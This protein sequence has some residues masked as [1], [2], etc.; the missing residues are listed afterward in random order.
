MS[1]IVHVQLRLGGS[2]AA[3][4]LGVAMAP[5]F[6]QGQAPAEDAATAL[7][8]PVSD[9]PIDAAAETPADVASTADIVV[10]G[11][12]IARPPHV[13]CSPIVTLSSFFFLLPSHLHSPHHY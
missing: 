8:P 7:S 4:A 1:S 3:L 10:T 12:L 13:S 11:S 6:A 9:A 5:A 2:L